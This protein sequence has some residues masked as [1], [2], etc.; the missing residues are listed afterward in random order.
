MPNGK[1]PLMIIAGVGGIFLTLFFSIWSITN[2]ISN[3][4]A[5]ELEKT[6]MEI[7]RQMAIQAYHMIDGVV[8]EEKIENMDEKLDEV[9]TDV[10]KILEK[11]E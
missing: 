7:C 2:A 9:L 4:Y 10:K 1:S 5:M 11:L 8:L 3:K 6:K